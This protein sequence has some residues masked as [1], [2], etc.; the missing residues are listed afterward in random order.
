MKIVSYIFRIAARATTLLIVV[1]MLRRDRR[2]ERRAA[3]W[4]LG[5]SMALVVGIFP[6]I[7][8]AVAGVIGIDVP[9]NLVFFVSF[10]LLVVVCVQH[11]TAD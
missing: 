8:D 11:S 3:L 6:S 2:R 5:G 4:L 1:N 10:A 9:T 7:L